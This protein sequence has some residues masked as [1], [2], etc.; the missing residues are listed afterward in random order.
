MVAMM[1]SLSIIQV[2]IPKRLSLVFT[3]SSEQRDGN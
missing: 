3:R 2:Q 1:I